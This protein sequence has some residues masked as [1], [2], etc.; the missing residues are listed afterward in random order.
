MRGA[1]GDAR[2]S[3]DWA[4]ADVDT[5]RCGGELRIDL[6][7]KGRQRRGAAADHRGVA[8]RFGL[9]CSGGDGRPSISWIRH[10]QILADCE[11]GREGVVYVGEDVS[12]GDALIVGGG[13]GECGGTLHFRNQGAYFVA[14]AK[15]A[16]LGGVGSAALPLGA[17]RFLQFPVVNIEDVIPGV[18][19]A[20]AGRCDIQMLLDAGSP[21]LNLRQGE[22][23]WRWYVSH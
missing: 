8:L 9:F 21:L 14:V 1:A 17:T 6:V 19:F 5:S 12:L 16:F 22:R 11:A 23:R 4:E 20:T 13:V 15:T 2:I 7:R 3:F 18:R 10:R